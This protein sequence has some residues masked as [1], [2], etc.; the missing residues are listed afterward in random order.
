MGFLEDLRNGD[1]KSIV[2]VIFGFLLF[3]L[4]WQS[5]CKD[6]KEPMADVSNDIKEAIKQ[7]YLADVE[8][9]RNLS[10]VATKLQKEGLTVPGNLT[11]TGSFNYLPKGSIIAYNQSSAPSGWTLCDGSNGSP[12]LR[13][14]FILGWGNR[15]VGTQGGE[16]NVTLNEGQMPN[17]YHSVTSRGDINLYNYGSQMLHYTNQRWDTPTIDRGRAPAKFGEI[18]VYG[19]TNAKGGNQPH[20]NMPPFYVLTYIMKL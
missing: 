17:H 20:N 2:L 7:V 5:Q 6:N 15:G 3:N 8:A 1:I 10:E 11:V 19:D 12:N 14:R 9:I 13:D 16:E 4:Y 18:S